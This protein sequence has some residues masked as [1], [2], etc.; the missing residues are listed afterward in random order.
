MN[1]SYLGF[2]AVI[3]FLSTGGLLFY[4]NRIVPDIKSAAI[5][6]V[7]MAIPFVIWDALVVGKWWYFNPD[8]VMGNT[9][10]SLPLEEVLF[11][12]VIP[13]STLVLW[14]NI[15]PRIRGMIQFPLE[16]YGVLLSL[17]VGSYSFI[18][19]WWYT[20]TV[21][22]G[23]GIL[24]F[25]SLSQQNFLRLKSVCLFGILVTLITSIFNNYLT[26]YIVSYN[27]SYVSGL[28]IGTMPLE[29]LFFGYILLGGIVMLYEYLKSKDLQT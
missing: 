28:R 27:S 14:V 18:Q 5:A 29:D 6:I 15:S 2:N 21:M 25:I 19:H 9:V 7:V 20:T 12:F 1:Y 10:F 11:F 23:C 24:L 8:R 3:L 17:I 26:T 16:E 13:W 4:K 22:V